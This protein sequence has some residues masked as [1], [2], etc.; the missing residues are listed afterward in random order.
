MNGLV[1]CLDAANTKSYPG[2]G[3]TWF[4]MSGNSNN[5]TLTNGLAF[6]SANIGSMSFDGV[7]DYF[8]I[9][10]PSITTSPTQQFSIEMWIKPDL[11]LVSDSIIVSPNSAGID[12]FIW[13]SPS[14]QNVD[15][16]ITELGDVNNRSRQSQ[17]NSVPKGI[18]SHLVF[19]MN[20]LNMKIYVNGSISAE[21]IETI[22][23]A[24]WNDYWRIG[25]RANGTFFYNGL[26]SN[27]KVY[28]K[29]LNAVEI[30]Q[31]FNATRGRYGI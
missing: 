17:A 13:Y 5:G 29:E 8:N 12:H 26:L 19:T 25:S 18:W 3:T 22:P 1:L 14:V 11:N 20:N 28:N 27:I 2:T 21:Y 30:K 4:D 6:D 15:F 10:Q 31:N 7:N 24:L 23:I 9:T 16:R